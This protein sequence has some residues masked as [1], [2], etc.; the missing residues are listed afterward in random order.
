MPTSTAS[1][2]LRTI[3]VT[4]VALL[5]ILALLATRK[6]LQI[7]HPSVNV[8]T[9]SQPALFNVPAALQIETLESTTSSARLGNVALPFGRQDH[10]FNFSPVSKWSPIKRVL[11]PQWQCLVEKGNKYIR[12]GVLPAFEGRSNFPTPA[13]TDASFKENG[14]QMSPPVDEP[15]PRHWE[16]AFKLVPEGAPAPDE[17]SEREDEVSRIYMDQT[18]PFTNA[19]GQRDT[20][21][22]GGTYYGLYL[23]EACAI[24]TSVSYSPTYSLEQA[25][26]AEKEIPSRIPPLHQ[27]SDV[28]WAVWESLLYEPGNLRYYAVGA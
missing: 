16:E 10:A 3:G 28:L 12:E 22:T 9:V 7:G 13:F 26:V 6:S 18:L 24:I 5:A 15:L 14:W 23:P 11:C 25:G 1:L 17:D 19:Q 20:P 4:L 8:L 2:G 27:L 21:P